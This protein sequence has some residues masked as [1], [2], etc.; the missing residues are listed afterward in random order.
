[1]LPGTNLRLLL[2]PGGA[3]TKWR[4]Q[5]ALRAGMLNTMVPRTK[6]RYLPRGLCQQ[7]IVSPRRQGT[8]TAAE[9]LASGP[10]RAAMGHQHFLGAICR[11]CAGSYS[12]DNSFTFIFSANMGADQAPGHGQTS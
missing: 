4:Q 2:P 12:R 11:V 9:V 7:L 5:R 8:S 6:R 3:S 10:P 1:M